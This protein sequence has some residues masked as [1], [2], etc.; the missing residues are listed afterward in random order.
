MML[1][2]KSK[3]SEAEQWVDG[4]ITNLQPNDLGEFYGLKMQI[5]R[6]GEFKEVK[7]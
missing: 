1:K 4:N 6:N 5:E 2:L 3:Y 7:N